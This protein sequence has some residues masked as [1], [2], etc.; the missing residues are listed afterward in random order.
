MICLDSDFIIDFFRGK[1]AVVA[2]ME[3]LKDDAPA[4]AA[5]T[6]FEVLY[7]FFRRNEPAKVQAAIDFF[8]SLKILDTTLEAAN[9]AARIAGELARQG[10]MVNE[11]DSLIAGSMLANGCKSIATSNVK[12]FGRI[13]EVSVRSP[14]S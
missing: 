5:I 14:Q 1:E 3:K 7:G 8:S 6:A 13:K 11:F 12:D 9:E 4:V 2:Q 10:Q